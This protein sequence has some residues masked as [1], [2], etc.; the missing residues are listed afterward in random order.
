M[1]RRQVWWTATVCCVVVGLVSR[2]P[3]AVVAGTS[4][5]PTL[6][7]GDRLV[8]LPLRAVPGRLVLVRDPRD[9]SRT[10]V[11]RVKDV[12]VDGRVAVTGDNPD[13]STD[14]RTFGTLPPSA[15]IGRP[16][17]RYNSP[18]AGWLWRA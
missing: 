18:A 12:T 13:A 2:L 15:V 1:S 6:Q 5:V 8:V 14:S 3:R 10:L 4:M 11:K 7:P 9:S 17:Y 16:A